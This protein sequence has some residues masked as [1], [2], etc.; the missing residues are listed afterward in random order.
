MVAGAVVADRALLG[1]LVVAG[2]VVGC[3]VLGCAVLGCPMLDGAVFAGAAVAGAAV[4][5]AVAD[6]AGLG[7]VVLDCAVRGLLVPTVWVVGRAL[8]GVPAA[9]TGAVTGSGSPAARVATPAAGSPAARGSVASV[10]RE[11]STAGPKSF[12]AP[13]SKPV[14]ARTQDQTSVLQPYPAQPDLRLT[15]SD[16]W[17]TSGLRPT[18]SA[19]RSARGRPAGVGRQGRP[20]R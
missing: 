5:G 15:T 7:W 12:T 19:V 17:A 1:G 13:K 16:L 20:V 18:T 8:L 4:D 3:A 6:W 11:T 2:A 10:F 14:R 9:R